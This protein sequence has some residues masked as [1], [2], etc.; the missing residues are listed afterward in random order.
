L[1]AG[2]LPSVPIASPEHRTLSTFDW[3]WAL[4]L[5]ILARHQAAAAEVCA[6]PRGDFALS[7]YVQEGPDQPFFEL[8]RQL[9]ASPSFTPLPALELCE[10]WASTHG[11]NAHYTYARPLPYLTVPYLAVVRALREGDRKS[12]QQAF[13]AALK[14]HK[15]YYGATPN[16]RI[17]K[18]GFVSMRL[19][20]L[21]ALMHDRGLPLDV[22]SDYMPRSWITGEV[23]TA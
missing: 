2:E 1:I 3:S 13:V 7:G 17:D 5:A 15:K 9:W 8:E 20:T 16:R 18:D 6:Y 22:Q 14:S 23:L 21:A 10:E 12:I 4:Q 19:T 11:P